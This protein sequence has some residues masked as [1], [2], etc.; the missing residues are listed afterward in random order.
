MSHAMDAL[1]D[2]LR[3]LEQE[4]ATLDHQIATLR[5]ILGRPDAGIRH[6]AVVSITKTVPRRKMSAAVRKVISQRMK[7]LWA[8]RRAVQAKSK[9][10]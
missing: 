5:S 4:K 3:Q 1:R 9:G 10:K 7:E 6:V 2:A 8:K